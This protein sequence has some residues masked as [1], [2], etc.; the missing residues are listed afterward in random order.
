MKTPF[1]APR[2]K[3]SFLIFLSPAG[4]SLTKLSL[5]G[6]N[7]VIYKL[8]PPRESLVSDIP[9]GD[10]NIEKLFL[11]CSFSSKNK[12]GSS[13][14]SRQLPRR[15]EAVGQPRRRWPMP[16]RLIFF[17]SRMSRAALQAE[18]SSGSGLELRK[19]VGARSQLQ[20]LLG[21]RF[22]GKVSSGYRLEL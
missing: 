4:M 11:Q 12:A 8:F 13:T 3:K 15:I 16:S 9:A 19:K 5:G 2:R 14:W 18:V 21:G 10:R 20:K 17:R 6:N 1:L 7:D 22:E